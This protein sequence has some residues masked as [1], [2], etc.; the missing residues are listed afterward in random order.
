MNLYNKFLTRNVGN[1]CIK[2]YQ[3][4]FGENGEV[5]ITKYFNSILFKTFINTNLEYTS[6]AL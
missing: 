1:I 6:V 3:H 2:L 4:P 5:H